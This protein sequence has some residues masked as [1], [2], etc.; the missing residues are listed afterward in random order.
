MHR[1]THGDNIVSCTNCDKKDKNGDTNKI[2]IDID[3][4]NEILTDERRNGI[5]YLENLNCRNI[6]RYDGSR[7]NLLKYSTTTSH[8]ITTTTVKFI[9][10]QFIINGSTNFNYICL[11]QINY[12]LHT[13]NSVNVTIHA[14]LNVTQTRSNGNL[15]SNMNKSNNSSD[16][17]DERN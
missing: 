10:N 17:I 12:L 14:S 8:T 15:N 13:N 6:I 7:D 5:F 2:V 9:T 11:L 4:E 16:D 1:P 3:E